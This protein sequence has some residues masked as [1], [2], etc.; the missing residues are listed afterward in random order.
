MQLM[1]REREVADFQAKMKKTEFKH[2]RD[3][4]EAKMAEDRAKN[5]LKEEKSRVDKLSKVAKERE[6]Q[7]QLLN[8]RINE[9]REKNEKE[10]LEV[11]AQYNSLKE[12]LRS[13]ERILP[14]L[15]FMNELKLS[16]ESIPT[17]EE[18][19]L[20]LQDKIVRLDE[21]EKRYKEFR[22]KNEEV[23]QTLKQNEELWKVKKEES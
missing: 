6:E 23:V 18:I 2:S 5:L 22:E 13:Y 9:L 12:E 7:N 8:R 3:I 16:M 20:G 14:T 4:K 17:Y 10:V 11:R 19:F 21:T 1:K 15:T